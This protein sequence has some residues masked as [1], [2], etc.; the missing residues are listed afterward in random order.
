MQLRSMLTTALAA[1]LCYFLA[2]KLGLEFTITK[3]GSVL[4]WPTSG[5]I[6]G[7][8]LVNPTRQWIPILVACAIAQYAATFGLY[9]IIQSFG[10]IFIN[11][12]ECFL[13]ATILSKLGVGSSIMSSLSNYGKFLLAGPF[14]GCLFAALI[15]YSAYSSP[16]SNAGVI[17]SLRTVPNLA[18]LWN[19]DALGML[20]ITP[21]IVALSSQVKMG[22]KF[23]RESMTSLALVAGCILFNW[24]TLDHNNTTKIN[25]A[26]IFLLLIPILSAIRNDLLATT[27]C[28]AITGLFVIESHVHG[29]GP[30][31]QYMAENA[32]RET[33]EFIAALAII[34][35]L[36]LSWAK[37]L[38]QMKW[39]MKL[40]DRAINTIQD[41]IMI[42]DANTKDLNVVFVNKTFETMTGY[43]T[44]EILGRS[45]LIL[46]NDDYD[47]ESLP[48][49]KTALDS[50]LP[51]SATVRNYRKDGKLFWN[52]VN[53]SPLF[54]SKNNLT[55]FVSVLHDATE[56]RV[57]L[58][59]LKESQSELQLQKK[60]LEIRVKQRT[61]E[62]AEA[63]TKLTKLNTELYEHATKDVLTG[64]ANRR[65]F[66]QMLELEAVRAQRQ[67]H[68]I[69]LLLFDIDFFKQIND[70]YGHPQGDETLKNVSHVAQ[71]V[72][73]PSD[74]IGRIG[75]E[76]FAVILAGCDQ[77]QAFKIAQRIRTE[78]AGHD[79]AIGK[80][81]T[82]K[83]TISIG[84]T[85]F[86][87]RTEP[88]QAAI[89]RADEAL[90]TAKS[91]GRNRVEWNDETPLSA[92]SKPG[93]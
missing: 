93:P 13:I 15:S 78:I 85:E 40:K 52:E 43:R 50:A 38:L 6:L 47:Q 12:L 39:E 16:L 57:L 18:T 74:V 26:P 87:P 92:A 30:F 5:I 46:L 31:D 68:S 14:I 2:V 17:E 7:F 37:T 77:G 24:A 75:G 9:S 49:I 63:N 21:L 79:T 41:A 82:I 44:D 10:I 3:D 86:F 22:V 48:V 51:V 69:F 55:H 61:K 73:R 8:L 4:F 72:L 28:T 53:I 65:H 42:S 25:L 56:T 80:D 90:Y 34:V 62:L 81:I 36:I 91:N 20:L 1:G 27:F 19:A 66:F 45:S 76:E 23:N 88:A 84:I 67:N 60:E 83:V 58:T 11:S 54:D 59:R 71:R 64:L 35:G 70:R 89:K 29:H 32:L 33:Q